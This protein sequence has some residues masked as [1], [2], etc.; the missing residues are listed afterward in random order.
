MKWTFVTLIIIFIHTA[1]YA[2]DPHPFSI[3][4]ATA[5]IQEKKV[6]LSL[7]V[8]AEDLLYFHQVP[9]DSFFIVSKENLLKAANDHI[10]TI[11]A[12]FLMLDQN[13]KSLKS[14][15]VGSNFSSLD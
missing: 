14:S 13:K 1:A 6:S 10:K 9:F 3:S 5:D 12:G 15:V 7:K 4:W 2:S 8:L 11:Q